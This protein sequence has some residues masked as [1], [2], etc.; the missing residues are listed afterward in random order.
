MKP[1]FLNTQSPLR[2]LLRGLIGISVVALL[3]GCGA[4]DEG[5]PEAT[6]QST[7]APTA[8]RSAIAAPDPADGPIV[9]YSSRKEHLIAPVFAA[10]TE[11]TG[12][13]VKYTTDKAG[14]LVER[15][16]AEGEAT[17][18]DLLMTV[19][20]GTL[21]YAASQGIL[22]PL[23]VAPVIERVAPQYR[24][25]NDLWT[26]LSLRAR[27]IVFSTERVDPAD[28][29]TYEALGDAQWSGR[30]CLRTSRKVYNQSLVAMLIGHHGEARAE[31]IVTRWVANLAI[32]PTSNDTKVMEA[33]VAGQCD[34][35]IVN[36]YYFGRLQRDNPEIPLALFWPN[37][38]GSGVHVNVAG[39][40]LLKHSQR[41]ELARYLMY[42]LV[43]V[44]A[45]ELYSSLNQE[46]P[47][48]VPVRVAPQVASWGEFEASKQ[49]LSDAYR[50]QPDAVKLMDRVGYE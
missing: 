9:V 13:E 44:K 8:S 24:D 30:L 3:A 7:S 43:S 29:S 25:D 26:G 36:S 34:V 45:Q 2:A 33:I 39:A 41:P 17:A 18:A 1:A 5:A 11:Q 50:L 21:G 38:G 49:P 10:F 15:I 46:Y 35:G 6:A 37:Q 28:L 40:G 23:A 12:I 19:D 27:T 48:V 31:D 32:P 22:Q 4:A 16:K 20:A 14:V 47:V 42:W